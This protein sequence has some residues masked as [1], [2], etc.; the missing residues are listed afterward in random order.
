MRRTQ[1]GRGRRQV[2]AWKVLAIF[3]GVSV[4]LTS[5]ALTRKTVIMDYLAINSS[6]R[7]TSLIVHYF[8]ESRRLNHLLYYLFY[9]I[10]SALGGSDERVIARAERKENVPHNTAVYVRDL[11]SLRGG[12]VIGSIK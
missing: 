1:P 2:I 9:P 11:D 12:A 3:V 7:G 4:Y 10:H 6:G 8:S 5:F